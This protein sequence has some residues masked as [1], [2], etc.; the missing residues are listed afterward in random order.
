[1]YIHR[2][3]YVLSS[4]EMLQ[5]WPAKP[6]P[7]RLIHH[8][9]AAAIPKPHEESVIVQ[10]LYVSG[11]MIRV[12]IERQDEPKTRL[13][14]LRSGKITPNPRHQCS[15]QIMDLIGMNRPGE[16]RESC[17][18]S[19]PYRVSDPRLVKKGLYCYA[20]ATYESS[21]KAARSNPVTMN[22]RHSW[23]SEQ[24]RLCLYCEDRESLRI[25]A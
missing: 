11:L 6:S 4:T 12:C 21:Q 23:D 10:P 18:A 24:L 25:L 16:S 17:A 8:S 5:H 7:V 3:T 20:S 1:V 2:Y 14:Q 19:G 15:R 13:N 22:R 9:N